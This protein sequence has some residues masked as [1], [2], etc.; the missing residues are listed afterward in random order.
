MSAFSAANLFRDGLLQTFDAKDFPDLAGL[1]YADLMRAPGGRLIGIPVQYRFYSIAFNTA[2]AK[3][4]D[5]P[6]WQSLGEPAW[7]GR[8][9]VP[10]AYAVDWGVSGE[11]CW[12]CEG[13]GQDRR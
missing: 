12:P 11:C 10:Q 13:S 6:S 3:A 5:F 9:A 8:I 2:Q 7:K 4:S 1:P